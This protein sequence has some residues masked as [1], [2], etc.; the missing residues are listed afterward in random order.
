MNNSIDGSI[1]HQ[2]SFDLRRKS[3]NPNAHSKKLPM[4]SLNDDGRMRRNN[5]DSSMVV[6]NNGG[7][8]SS[9]QV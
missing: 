3:N 2:Q 4:L 9:F 5:V 7:N 6:H 1:P 8:Q